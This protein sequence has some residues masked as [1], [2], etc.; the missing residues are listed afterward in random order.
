MAST[1]LPS[2]DGLCFLRVR[3]PEVHA[4]ILLHEADVKARGTRDS[5]DEQELPTLPVLPCS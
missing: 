5:R 4:F 2:T 1:A 3:A